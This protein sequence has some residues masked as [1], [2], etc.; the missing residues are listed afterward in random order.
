MQP[1][2]PRSL[3]DVIASR[4]VRHDITIV[5]PTLGRPILETCLYY[6][7]TGDAWPE[8][9][10]VVDQGCQPAVAA[11]LDNLRCQGMHVEYVP[12]SQRGKAAGVNRGFER[13]STA[14]ACVTDDDCFVASDWVATLSDRL[15][16]QPGAIWTGRA[17]LAGDEED[18]F[19]TVTDPRKKV[20]TKP[21]LRAHPFVG[22]NF[23]IAMEIARRIGPFDEHPC[24][25]AAAEDVDYGF[26]AL[27]LGTP[28]VY[29]PA[30]LVYHFHWRDMSQRVTRY[31]EYARSQG[32]F[33]G[34]HLRSA[35]P[36][37]LLQ[38]VRALIRSPIRWIR[39]VLTGK[40]DMAASGKATTLNLIPGIVEGWR[41]PPETRPA[42][43]RRNV[44]T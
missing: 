42:S 44:R 18:E 29:D 35:D 40:R 1:V 24:L 38:V 5:I 2:Y 26:R 14:F 37:I 20:Y 11:M 31:G 4:P 39:G 21:Q 17:E 23:G 36:V 25:A 32:A 6:I 30:V 19:C 8:K 27:R 34:T 41:R 10:I 3:D 9:L 16:E 33:Y 43:G 22:G 28:I 13:V 12:S 15:R 7:A